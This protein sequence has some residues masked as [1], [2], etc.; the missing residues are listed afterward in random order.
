MKNIEKISALL[1]LNLL[2]IPSLFAQI[3]FE[4]RSEFRISNGDSK[5]PYS[6]KSGDFNNDGFQDI[7]IGNFASGSEDELTVMIN[8]QNGDFNITGLTASGTIISIDTVDLNN[9]GN[10]DTGDC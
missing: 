4:E 3:E 2:F 9:D 1:L 7:V 5:N 8:N 6:M 10:L